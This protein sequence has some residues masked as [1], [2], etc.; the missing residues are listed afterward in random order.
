M[1]R[2]RSA[3]TLV[4]KTEEEVDTH[5]NIKKVATKS[6]LKVSDTVSKKGKGFLPFKKSQTSKV[7]QQS[8]GSS[9]EQD[10]GASQNIIPVKNSKLDSLTSSPSK[11][12]PIKNKLRSNLHAKLSEGISYST[13]R[14]SN[15][16]SVQKD[17]PATKETS[18]VKG[19]V[20]NLVLVG[21]NNT[22]IKKEV[23]VPSTSRTE[24]S[25]VDVPNKRKCLRSS[26][27][28]DSARSKGTKK[29]NTP[30]T[31]IKTESAGSLK[32]KTGTVEQGISKRDSRGKKTGSCASSR[33]SSIQDLI[34]FWERDVAPW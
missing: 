34:N 31:T 11:Y 7:L 1:N 28:S 16:F 20:N 13:K 23:E 14:K 2:K 5:I 30:G 12:S 10:S 4:V 18:K 19:G 21:K 24:D 32:K 3:Q 8:S 25:C 15:N 17:I 27:V 26:G 9:L 22:F 6:K 29:A 33:Y